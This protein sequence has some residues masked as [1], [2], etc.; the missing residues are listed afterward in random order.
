M[1]QDEKRK[2]EEKRRDLEE[3]MNAFNNK[4][5]MAAETVSL[6]QPLKK[7]KDKKK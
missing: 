1:H 4:K 6:S 5:K 2:V 7:D 3:E